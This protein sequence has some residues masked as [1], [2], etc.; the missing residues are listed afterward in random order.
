MVQACNPGT[1]EVEADG[2]EAYMRPC[3]QTN[4]VWSPRY[5]SQGHYPHV[6]LG[7]T[8]PL[9]RVSLGA[10]VSVTASRKQPLIMDRQR[11]YQHFIFKIEPHE[12]QAD[13]ELLA[14]PASIPNC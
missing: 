11:R 8:L 2:V 14:L 1:Q 10:L 13:L 12:V 7:V 9:P 6:S 5:P 3:L 4:T